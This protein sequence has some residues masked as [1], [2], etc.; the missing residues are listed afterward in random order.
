[1][2]AIQ[3]VIAILFFIIASL[4]LFQA[5]RG[6]AGLRAFDI[7]GAIF[8]VFF[9]IGFIIWPRVVPRDVLLAGWVM[10][11]LL[12]AWRIAIEVKDRRRRGEMSGEQ[13]P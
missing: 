8:M 4:S 6:I 3:V 2:L 10:V 1:M 11:G 13:K 12:A 5:A 7:V 9:G